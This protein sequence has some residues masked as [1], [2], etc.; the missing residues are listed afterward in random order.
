MHN[1][2]KISRTIISTIFIIV[3][4]C[5]GVGFICIPNENTYLRYSN[6]TL[7]YPNK[8]YDANTNEKINSETICLMPGESI[9]L[10]MKMPKHLYKETVI[11]FYDPGFSISVQDESKKVI[12]KSGDEGNTVFG[13]ELGAVWRAIPISKYGNEVITVNLDNVLNRSL[14]LDLRYFGIVHNDYIL[15]EILNSSWLSIAEA[16]GC[17]IISI[18]LFAF[19]YMVKN[20]NYRQTESIN[21]A[22]SFTALAVG[23]WVFFSGNITQLITSNSSIRYAMS[24]ISFAL[25][26]VL[27]LKYFKG[28]FKRQEIV[29]K[30]LITIYQVIVVGIFL[31]HIYGFVPLH[32]SIIISFLCFVLEAAILFVSAITEITRYHSKNCEGTLIVS[33]IMLVIGYIT[34]AFYEE[35]YY[36]YIPPMATFGYM[37]CMLVISYTDIRHVRNALKYKEKIQ[38]YKDIAS[39]DPV[40]SGN[41]RIVA[42]EW[43]SAN[44]IGKYSNVWLL[45]M[46]IRN[47][48]AVNTMVGWSTGDKIL[49]DIYKNNLNFLRE[50]DLLCS[51]GD[52]N[53]IFI[54]TNVPDISKICKK[55]NAKLKNYSIREYTG[56]ELTADFAALKVEHEEKLDKLLECIRLSRL[57]KLA[58]YDEDAKCFFYNDKCREEMKKKIE[59]ETKMTTAIKDKEFKM[60]LQP[61]VSPIDNICYGAEAL[62][63]WISSDLGLILP[64]NFISIFEGNGKIK[65]LD[66]YMFRCVCEYLVYRKKNNLKPIKISVNISKNDIDKADF[67]SDYKKIICELDVPTENLEFEFTESTAFDDMESIRNLILEMHKVG[68]KV[69]MDDFGSGY[70]NIRAIGALEFDVVKMDKKFLD[71]GF[72]DNKKDYVLIKGLIDVFH[73][74]GISVVCE[75]VED[76]RQKNALKELGAD[77]IQGYFYSKPVS[78]NEFSEWIEAY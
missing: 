37:V 15:I 21:T 8:W 30:N 14:K 66:V 54:L 49:K 50:N 16:L 71:N 47:F 42:D 32:N 24:Y 34:C 18:I 26:P 76:E 51:M 58:D 12:Y 55:I 48:S 75:G 13:K 53:F 4:V 61:K 5:A 3:L 65:T 6:S 38:N 23:V 27:I 33:I 64:D 22:S 17:I 52:S 9:S 60:F 7:E 40:T 56:L 1:L 59:Y 73:D 35:A 20:V 41:S 69:S 10:A 70:S 67:F 72:P 28:F 19:S 63:R 11:G 2:Q 74:M 39:V 29:F 31:L 78:V 25:I 36:N 77:L 46:D 57:S 43:I 68:A 44:D 45:H 62:V